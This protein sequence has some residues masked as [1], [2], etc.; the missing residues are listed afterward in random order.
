MSMINIPN[1]PATRLALNVLGVLGVILALHLGQTVFIP[2]IIALLLA[3]VLGPA[4]AWLHQKLKIR[5]TLACVTVVFLLVLINLFILGVFAG[6]VTKM[7]NAFPQL[8]DEAAQLAL[9]KK[10]YKQV[11]DSFPIPLDPDIFPAN[12]TSM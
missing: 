6:S 10:L 7:L 9:Y 4:A 1:T 2:T 5:W 11:E 8:N 12:P 3:S